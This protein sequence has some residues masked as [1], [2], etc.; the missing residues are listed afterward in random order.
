MAKYIHLDMLNNWK[1]VQ[2]GLPQSGHLSASGA[3]YYP[4]TSKCVVLFA[5]RMLVT[6]SLCKFT[7]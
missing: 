4:P 5:L 3:N 2:L 7:K 1:T 6:I